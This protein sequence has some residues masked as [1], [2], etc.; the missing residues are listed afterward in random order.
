MLIEQYHLNFYI[1]LKKKSVRKWFYA[2]CVG[3]I[4]GML[5]QI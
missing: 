1:Q 2:T 5:V 4:S 3:D